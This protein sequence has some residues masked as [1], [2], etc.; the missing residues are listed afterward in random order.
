VLVHVADGIGAAN[1]N[2]DDG[3][4]SVSMRNDRVGATRLLA[5]LAAEYRIGDTA[6]R[7][8][9]VGDPAAMLG[10]IAAEEAGDLIVLGSRARGRFRRGLESRL[11]AVLET[12]TT[13]PVV[14]APPRDRGP[15]V[16]A[17]SA[18]QR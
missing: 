1:G 18:A 17:R 3:Y 2:G 7:R 15:R 6:E 11:A 5:R 10:Q 12:A 13:V 14:I 4:E 16:V 8:E 9:A